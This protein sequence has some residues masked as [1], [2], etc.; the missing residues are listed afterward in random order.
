LA[1]AKAFPSFC[2]GIKVAVIEKAETLAGAAS[3]GNSGLGCTG[4]GA[5]ENKSPMTLAV[6]K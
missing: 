2:R 1:S 3:G 6:I 4:G 5:V